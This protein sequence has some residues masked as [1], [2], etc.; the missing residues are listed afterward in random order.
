MM[1]KS[2]LGFAT[3]ALA[4]AC[5]SYR[6]VQQGMAPRVGEPVH[7]NL[8][9]AGTEELA[10]YLGPRVKRAEGRLV[11]LSADGSMHVAV[12]FVSLVDGVKQP[13]SGEGQVTFPPHLVENVL[14]RRFEKRRTIVGS[15]AL[16]GALIGIAIVA[17]QQGGGTPGTGGGPPPPTASPP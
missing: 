6:P 1:Q 11:S 14:E 2:I 17:I 13:W 9:P 7:L 16:A 4:T 5:Y 15:T 3:L 8:T 10:R 12:D